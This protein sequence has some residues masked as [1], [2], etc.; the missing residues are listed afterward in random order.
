MSGGDKYQ[1]A[2]LRDSPERCG[3]A[4]ESWVVEDK[5]G[6]CIEV[7]NYTRE[8]SAFEVYGASTKGPRR[9]R[10]E[11]YINSGVVCRPDIGVNESIFVLCDG[12]G[13]RGCGD[14][15]AKLVAEKFVEFYPSWR[16]SNE[17]S[18]PLEAGEALRR[19]ALWV[20]DELKRNAE[21]ANVNAGTTAIV[22]VLD[23]ET[24]KFVVLNVGDSSASVVNRKESKRFTSRH[25][26][27]TPKHGLVNRF[28]AK[29]GSLM[30]FEQDLR[31]LHESGIL[32]EDPVM[33]HRGTLKPGLAIVL[34][35]DGADLVLP[36]FSQLLTEGMSDGGKVN[37]ARRIVESANQ[38]DGRDNASAIVITLK[39]GVEIRKPITFENV[40]TAQALFEAV[41]SSNQ[42]DL[43]AIA[44]EVL[45][46]RKSLTDVAEGSF[47][48]ALETV[49][50]RFYTRE[51]L[52]GGYQEVF[53]GAHLKWGDHSILY[54]MLDAVGPI[55]GSR[56]EPYDPEELK[57]RILD[58][59]AE[60]PRRL[61]K[62]IT[63]MCGLRDAV[64]NMLVDRETQRSAKK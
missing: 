49:G 62:T 21:L 16:C 5:A 10:D 32:K 20:D 55:Q 12:I 39:K 63:R 64:E 6:N 7:A 58:V 23:E 43:Y 18:G 19:T 4:V 13:G 57:G 60:P 26:D 33:V 54:D 38:V 34:A 22:C 46:G 15:A 28:S 30:Y 25:E 56:S 45:S 8:D 44:N 50:C 27:S 59:L 3:G 14:E 29:K 11:D 61:S 42:K 40:C 24:G 52:K 36:N 48:I 31:R 51:M 35:C 9:T 17:G 1:P 41:E 53:M 37:P 2:I 47:K